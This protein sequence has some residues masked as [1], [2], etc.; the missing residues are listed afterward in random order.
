M[1]CVEATSDSGAEVKLMERAA[2]PLY[3]AL[4]P[5]LALPSSVNAHRH[6]PTRVLPP[7]G[8]RLPPPAPPPPPGV[9]HGMI[10]GVERFR[11]L[12]KVLV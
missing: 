4:R 12:V 10:G 1:S 9:Q 8:S 5:A 2:A 3:I 11:I 6:R 7:A